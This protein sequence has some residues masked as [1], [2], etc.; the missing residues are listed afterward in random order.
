MCLPY[1]E[2]CGYLLTMMLIQIN[3]KH[4][5]DEKKES[6]ILLVIPFL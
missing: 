6:H 1:L 4:Y 3:H 5:A 2:T